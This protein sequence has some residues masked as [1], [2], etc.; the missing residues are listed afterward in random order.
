MAG[1]DGEA[2]TE[3]SGLN[4]RIRMADSAGDDLDQD[5]TSRGVL[6][7]DM[8]YGEWGLG[9][10]KD[11]CSVGIGK[12]RHIRNSCLGGIHEVEE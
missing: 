8:L 9:L 4:R 1:D 6:E 3:L 10:L 12:R 11:G 7:F 2:V 5:F